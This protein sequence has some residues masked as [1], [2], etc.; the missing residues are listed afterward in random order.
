MT[1]IRLGVLPSVGKLADIAQVTF[2]LF[3]FERT[4]IGEGLGTYGIIGGEEHRAEYS[5]FQWSPHGLS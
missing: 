3:G 2:G 1:E 4:R 5:E